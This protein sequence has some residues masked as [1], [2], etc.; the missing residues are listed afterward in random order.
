MRHHRPGTG[1]LAELTAN[2]VGAATRFLEGWNRDD[3]LKRF[4]P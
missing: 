3:H 2:G 1:S 4:Y